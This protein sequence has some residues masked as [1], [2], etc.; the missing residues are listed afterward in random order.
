MFK[1]N[2]ILAWFVRL[3]MLIGFAAGVGAAILD[4]HESVLF[5]C[6]AW[7]FGG[8]AFLRLMNSGD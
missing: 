3:T 8:F 1:L 5:L 6:W 4:G 7:V 2:S